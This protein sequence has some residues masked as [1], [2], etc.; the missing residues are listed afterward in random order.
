MPRITRPRKMPYK[1][2]CLKV[3]RKTIHYQDG[4]KKT[5]ITRKV[6]GFD[7]KLTRQ[8][9]LTIESWSKAK[10]TPPPKTHKRKA[11]VTQSE[12]YRLAVD[13]SFRKKCLIPR[14]HKRRI[15]KD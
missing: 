7:R 13:D 10:M 1:T 5:I 4:T 12:H 8:T 14:N 11:S 3:H 15:K 6:F 9:T 2:I